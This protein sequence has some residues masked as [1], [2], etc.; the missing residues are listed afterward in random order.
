VIPELR[1]IP[2]DSSNQLRGIKHISLMHDI[3]NINFKRPN[4]HN[5]CYNTQ[6]SKFMLIWIKS[7][8]YLEKLLAGKLIYQL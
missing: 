6:L 7:P 1:Y 5:Y 2:H 3:V 4:A 8:G